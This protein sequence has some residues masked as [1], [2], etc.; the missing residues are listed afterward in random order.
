MPNFFWTN[1]MSRLP[2]LDDTTCSTDA[3]TRVSAVKNANGFIPNLIGVLAHSPQ[4][5]EMYQ[6]VGK[7]NAKNSLS[8]QDVE[9]VQLVAARTN[10]CDFCVA[11]HRKIGNKIGMA[12][13][14]LDDL[15]Y[16]NTLADPK[17]QALATFTQ[18]LIDNR[19]KVSDQELQAITDAGYSAQNVLDI[20]M[21]VALATLCNYA[22]NV[23]QNTIN[24]E[25]LPFLPNS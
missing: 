16:K 7:L 13:D 15:H 20:I 17:A 19:G 14:L 24:D 21:G 9:I 5:L 8:P 25:L 4:A 6:E 1:L 18:A 10:G 12:Q 3:A 2:V 22:N 23:A 11:G